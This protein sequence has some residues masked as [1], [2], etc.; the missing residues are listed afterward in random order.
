[1]LKVI[2]VNVLNNS[3]EVI[4][5]CKCRFK[6]SYLTIKVFGVNYFVK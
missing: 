2:K 6:N 5:L 4:K 1:M 3:Y